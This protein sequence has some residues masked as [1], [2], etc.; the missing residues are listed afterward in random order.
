MVRDDWSGRE[1][2]RLMGFMGGNEM[3]HVLQKI[4]SNND[5]GKDYIIR[6]MG[7]ICT[8][9]SNNIEHPMIIDQIR[10]NYL[11]PNGIKINGADMKMSSLIDEITRYQDLVEEVTF[12]IILEMFRSVFVPNYARDKIIQEIHQQFCHEK[13]SLEEIFCLTSNYDYEI[14]L[15]GKK[16]FDLNKEYYEIDSNDGG[17]IK[18]L[19]HMINLNLYL[20]REWDNFSSIPPVKTIIERYHDYHR[21]GYLVVFIMHRFNDDWNETYGMNHEIIRILHEYKEVIKIKTT[22]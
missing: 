15:K 13:K 22:F 19:A 17:N 20:R 7:V 8:T 10:R 21:W 16:I 11:L 4:Y 3:R 18:S 1:L 12:Y 6:L 9:E 14:Y 5:E 2:K